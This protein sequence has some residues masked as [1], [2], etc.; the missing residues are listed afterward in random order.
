VTIG[1][2]SHP[3]DYEGQNSRAIV[4]WA[5]VETGMRMVRDPLAKGIDAP[6]STA[7]RHG[8]LADA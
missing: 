4:G 1:L 6:M 5:V 2:I 3:C 8:G 7:M